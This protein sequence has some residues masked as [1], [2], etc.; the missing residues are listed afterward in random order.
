MSPAKIMSMFKHDGLKAMTTRP[1]H[2]ATAQLAH[3]LQGGMCILH[4]RNNS[5]SFAQMHLQLRVMLQSYCRA[6]PRLL[7][8]TQNARSK[9]HQHLPCDSCLLF[10]ALLDT[11]LVGAS[12]VEAPLGSGTAFSTASP[13]LSKAW[14]TSLGSATDWTP[15]PFLLVS[16]AVGAAFD[17]A[18]PVHKKRC[19][20]KTKSV[21]AS[22]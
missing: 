20:G 13:T 15:A 12:P 17:G 9:L 16:L 2:I 10:S 22:P 21:S 5:N 18:A 14:S 7:L 11:G 1:S 4:C 3:P 6:H 19:Q 8:Q